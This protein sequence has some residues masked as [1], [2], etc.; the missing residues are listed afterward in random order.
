[1]FRHTRP[2]IINWLHAD[3]HCKYLA[4]TTE[5]TP[6]YLKV[7]AAPHTTYIQLHNK[8]QQQYHMQCTHRLNT[9]HSPCLLHAGTHRLNTQHSPCLLHAVYM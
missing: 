8:V 3:L 4:M 2:H 6:V 1:M 7:N 5:M 9:Q